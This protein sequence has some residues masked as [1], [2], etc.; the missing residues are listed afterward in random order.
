MRFGR[1]DQL[2]IRHEGTLRC[3]IAWQHVVVVGVGPE[4][5]VDQCHKAEAGSY[6]I[7]D[8][9]LEAQVRETAELKGLIH[10]L[11]GRTRHADGK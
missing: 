2:A 5:G 9:I 10:D 4:L 7:A 6:R 8:E 1:A 3:P 11:E